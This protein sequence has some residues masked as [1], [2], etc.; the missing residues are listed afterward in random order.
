MRVFVRESGTENLLTTVD[1][2]QLNSIGYLKRKLQEKA[3]LPA[4]EFSLYQGEYELDDDELLEDYHIVSDMETV[5]WIYKW[6]TPYC[7]GCSDCGRNFCQECRLCPADFHQNLCPACGQGPTVSSDNI[8]AASGTDQAQAS[9][10]DFEPE[11]GSGSETSHE[12]SPGLHSFYLSTDVD[13]LQPFESTPPLHRQTPH[14]HADTVADQQNG[15]QQQMSQALSEANA[16]ARAAFESQAEADE[17]A[18]VAAP[19]ATLSH[20][21]PPVSPGLVAAS[22]PIRGTAAT[23]IEGNTGHSNDSN[24]VQLGEKGL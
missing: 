11:A 8:A 9:G 16:R 14:G 19:T 15:L 3:G 24:P 7:P 22:A 12:S 5:L 20:D 21:L 13:P 6:H 1:V 17:P 10:P 2:E 23:A 18:A 4:C